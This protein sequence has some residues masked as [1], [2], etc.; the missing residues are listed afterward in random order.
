MQ[1]KRS[2]TNGDDAE[3][4]KIKERENGKRLKENNEY[5]LVCKED[6]SKPGTY[7]IEEEGGAQSVP[8]SQNHLHILGNLPE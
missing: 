3:E 1:G 7:E 2:Q 6:G 4:N 8:V 5:L